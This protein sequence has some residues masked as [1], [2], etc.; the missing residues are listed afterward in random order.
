MPKQEEEAEAKTC[1]CTHAAVDLLRGMSLVKG[2]MLTEAKCKNCGKPF[3]TNF[4]TE[5]CFD[6]GRKIKGEE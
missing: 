4:D 3:L 6:C 1:S 2:G 5:Y